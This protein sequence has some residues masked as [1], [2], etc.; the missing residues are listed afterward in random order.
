MP[1]HSWLF[2]MGHPNTSEA[3]H[4]DFQLSGHEL[5]KFEVFS[6]SSCCHTWLTPSYL[7]LM[8]DRC[9]ELKLPVVCSTSQ[10]VIQIRKAAE[11]L[12]WGKCIPQFPSSWQQ[13]LTAWHPMFLRRM[14][15]WHLDREL[16]SN[17]HNGTLSPVGSP[18]E[19]DKIGIRIISLSI[20]LFQVHQASVYGIRN[21]REPGMLRHIHPTLL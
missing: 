13:L 20:P 16:L 11:T 5:G 12:E 1:Q 21:L 7:Q 18:T 10:T 9:P 4:V 14:L 3:P 8:E 15:T 17:Q 19:T 6:A 2:P